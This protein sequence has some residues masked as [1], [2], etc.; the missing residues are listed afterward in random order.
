MAKN[1]QIPVSEFMQIRDAV[2]DELRKG[3]SSGTQRATLVRQSEALIV[4]GF[5]DI[6]AVRESLTPKPSAA[7]RP[8]AIEKAK[9]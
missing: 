5:I 4:S 9:R 7:G 8:D 6:D 1:T 3:T 2:A